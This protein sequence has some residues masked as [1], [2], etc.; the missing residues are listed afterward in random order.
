MTDLTGESRLQ[1]NSIGLAHIVFFV[2]AAAAPMTA[3]VGATPPAFAFGNG[4]GVPGA[5]VLA[6]VLYLLFSVGYTAMT[7]YI[8]GAGGFFSYISK[9]FGGAAGIGGALMALLAYFAIQ[10][11][12]YALFA[13]F[14]ASTLAPLGLDLP[15]WVW[16]LA[17]LAVVVFFGRRNI[18]ISGRI[19]GACMVAEMVILLLLDGAILL[20]GGGPE[21]LTLSGF[22][23]SEVFAPGLGVSMVFVLGA[24]VGFEATAIF[25]EEA[26]RPERTI[27]RATYVAVLL[28]T[29]FYALS[30]WAISQYYGPSHVRDAAT[31]SLEGF[32]FDAAADLLGPWSVTVMNLLLLTSLFACLLSFHNTLNRYFYTLASE[33]LL[34]RKMAHVHAEHGSPHVAGAVQ[35][36]LVALILGAF[37]LGA[38]DPYTVVFSWMAGLAVLAILA[39]QILV[40]AS[41]IRFFR[42]QS[43]NRSAL[44]VLVAPALA[45]LGLAAAFLL[46]GS[47]ISMLTGSDS[48]IVL[49]FPVLVIATGAVGALIALGV[50]A[51]NP[52]L[53]AGL[54]RS[55]D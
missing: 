19:L 4:A 49:A 10:I 36:V 30:T 1:G 48:L 34:W 35:A 46:V 31:A 44:V 27:P 38:A 51:R 21:G 14:M 40:S 37:A 8:S 6:G 15:W 24:Y 41:V 11:G 20:H 50:K 29:I 13:V 23:P 5:F 16:A 25:A 45:T 7:P 26:H 22:R 43:H 32:Y 39:T 12:I 33:S 18:A 2:V 9:G 28:I 3:V 52:A 42:R 47:N 54:G 53:Y 55:L 17:V